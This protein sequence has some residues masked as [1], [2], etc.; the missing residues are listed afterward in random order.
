MKIKKSRGFTLIE[1]LVVIAIIGILAAIVLV[2]LSGAR[3]KA[4]DAKIQA[5]MSGL[6]AAAE[7]YYS[8]S[9]KYQAETTAISACPSASGTTS[10]LDDTSTGWP[11]VS[12]TGRDLG[13]TLPD[14]TKIDCGIAA[15]ATADAWSVAVKLNT[16]FYCVD[17]TG[18]AKSTQGSGATPYT[19]V[20]GATTAAHTSSGSTVC[21]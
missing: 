13:A 18:A 21:N 20:S 1:L 17:S 11:L 4:K 2:S 10:F 14:A 9:N 19:A 15:P 6:R 16:G 5:Q 7:M 12:A 3:N 8:T